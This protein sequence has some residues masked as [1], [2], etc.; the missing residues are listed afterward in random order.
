M[1]ASSLCNLTLAAPLAA[2]TSKFTSSCLWNTATIPSGTT[3]IVGTP[4]DVLAGVA[5]CNNGNDNGTGT[6]TTELVWVPRVWIDGVETNIFPDAGEPYNLTVLI[7]NSD[8][9][10][11]P[12]ALRL[13]EENGMSIF[14]PTQ[15]YTLNTGKSGVIADSM[16]RVTT[17]N[18][19]YITFAVVPTGTK[20]YEPEFAYLN[21][22]SYIGNHSIYFEI[23]NIATGAELQLYFN[24]SKQD[25]FSFILVNM[26]PR[27]PNATEENSKVVIN[28]NMLVKEALDLAYRS[29]ATAVRWLK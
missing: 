16:S 15:L 5:D 13:V 1:G 12:V 21:T 2:G 28:Q 23:F 11:P 18:T 9:L 8:G 25:K 17:D 4:R 22:S 20:L 14:S 26:S 29:L 27:S 3:T 7:N 24:G 19:G 6:F 10:T